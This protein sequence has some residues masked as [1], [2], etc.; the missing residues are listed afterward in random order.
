[1]QPRASCCFLDVRRCPAPLS[2][3]RPDV[4][5][6]S[7]PTCTHYGSAAPLHYI[8]DDR[9]CSTSPPE[10]HRWHHTRT[11]LRGGEVSATVRRAGTCT[12][13]GSKAR[14]SVAWT[15]SSRRFGHG[16]QAFRSFWVGEWHCG[17]TCVGRRCCVRW[18]RELPRKGLRCTVLHTVVADAIKEGI[19]CYEQW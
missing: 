8:P 7:T 2:A 11:V 14:G 18:S 10:G 17:A 12:E 9:S 16:G 5:R 19:R 13:D 1:M 15:R 3:S 6:R 4:R